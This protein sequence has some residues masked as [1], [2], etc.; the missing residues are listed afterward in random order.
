LISERSGIESMKRAVKREV[1]IL[2]IFLICIAGCATERDIRDRSVNRYVQNNVYSNTLK[3]YSFNWPPS[4][5][6]N[7][8][9]YPEAD[10]SFDHVD[11][12]SQLF[13]IGVRG[14]IRRDY[15]EG[16]IT[17]VLDRLQAKNV[18]VISRKSITDQPNDMFQTILNCKF[19][20]LSG[21]AFGVERKVM[22][23]TW[24]NESL[25]LAAVY[26]APEKFFSTYQSSAEKIIDSI[27]ITRD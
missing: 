26:L 15:P 1:F 13:I 22:I 7:Y 11:G 24:Q 2:V 19:K 6:W 8:Q 12:R 25:W 5:L 4:Q 23:Y 21:E 10:I 16:F 9:D 18:N 17:W 3:G 14:L 20:I 27:E